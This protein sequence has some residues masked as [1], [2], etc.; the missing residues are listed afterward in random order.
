MEEQGVEQPAGSP[1]PQPETTRGS[2][3]YAPELRR[4]EVALLRA[5]RE[6][7]RALAGADRPGVVPEGDRLPDDAVGFALSGGGIRSATFC[8]GVFQA[9]SRLG[10]LHRI[11]FLSTV[12]GGGYFGG[13][14]GALI[15]RAV[16]GGEAEGVARAADTLSDSQSP[17]MRW[18]RENGRYMA[19]N[20]SGDEILAGAV[21]LR[22]LVAVHVVLATEIVLALSAAALVRAV[23]LSD[24]WAAHVAPAGGTWRRLLLGFATPS[25]WWSPY[26]V[27]PVVLALLVAFPLGWAYWFVQRE[28]KELRTFSDY[29]AWPTGALVCVASIVM[30]WWGP[31]EPWVFWTAIFFASTS[32]MAL[33]WWRLANRLYEVGREGNGREG[34]AEAGDP[35]ID[36]ERFTR[37][38]LSRWLAGSLWAAIWLGGF[39]LIDSFGQSI[40]AWWCATRFSELTALLTGGGLL[41]LLAALRQLAM[42][43]SQGPGGRRL[44]LPR[45]LLTGAV[46]A[47]ATVSLLVT[48]SA[49]THGIAWAG[50]TPEVS[51]WRASVTPQQVPV[52][53]DLPSGRIVAQTPPAP[54]VRFSE[55]AATMNL[56]W[57]G[58]LVAATLVLTLLFGHTLK[59]VNQSSHQALY[60]ARLTRAFLGASNPR[61]TGGVQTSD[62]TE[63]LAGDDIGWGL[64]RPH[65]KGGP[66]HIVN[67]TINETVM[68]ESGIE[69]RD[70]KGIPMAIGPSG[71]SAGLRYHALW[72]DTGSTD[73]VLPLAGSREGFH[74][75]FGKQPRDHRVEALSLGSW[76]AISGAAF[77][78]GLGHQ[79]SLSLSL[80]LGLANIRLGY[81]WDSHVHPRDR[82]DAGRRETLGP[83]LNWALP[84]QSH[85]FQEFFAR[86]YGPHR[87]RWYLSDGGHF[88]NTACYELIRRRVPFI[89]VCD[90]GRDLDYTFEDLGGLIRKARID[91]DA[92]IRLLGRQEIDGLVDPAL[93]ALIGTPAEFAGQADA[94]RHRGLSTDCCR[95]HALLA[96]VHYD[97]EPRPGSLILF[98]KPSLTGDEPLDVLQYRQQ[99]DQFPQESTV[100]QY[101]DEAQWESYRELGEHIGMKLF[102]PV[103]TPQ[104][105]C[106]GDLC[107]PAVGVAPTGALAP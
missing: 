103:E 79:T 70:R 63:P 92:D 89:V 31:R 64:Y 77:T 82:G 107:R 57:L 72:P 40:Y 3:V 35:F 18:L 24:W 66:L 47:L 51:A 95:A 75:F 59:F 14:L 88:E 68:G 17:P 48:L 10:L 53:V 101:F 9:L 102:G 7:A 4:R 34:R 22:N 100:D 105:W 15:S 16:P 84:V 37:S 2:V 61:R 78:T 80:L 8:L 11:D 56:A 43:L 96:W 87:R 1:A 30:A 32:A 28:K 26:V 60:S 33:A 20:G 85:L 106:P 45:A 62:V 5:R 6:K 55:T 69:Q 97:G 38:A 21:Y 74:L 71:L 99:H 104:G 86:F 25:L 49:V 41:A 54:A 76:V 19:P 23:P 42:G 50:R 29:A 44:S 91:F 81:W 65:L 58:V 90:D 12:S 46:A 27:I 94:A 98:L 39:A 67:V 52:V 13:F 73:R 93:S 83:L 36:R